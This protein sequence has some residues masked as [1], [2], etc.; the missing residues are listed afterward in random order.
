MTKKHST[1]CPE[2]GKWFVRQANFCHHC[3]A[4]VP[5]F[6]QLNSSIT[7]PAQNGPNFAAEGKRNNSSGSRSQRP[8]AMF[9]EAGII[10][11]LS[12]VAVGASPYYPQVSIGLT[13]PL[14]AY[15]VP[16]ILPVV[17]SSVVE[18]VRVWR[19]PRP[20]ETAFDTKPDSQV[21]K[22]EHIDQHGRPRLLYDFPETIKL[23]HLVHIAMRLES[24]KNFSRRGMVQSGKLSQDQFEA[25]AQTLLSMRLA[26]R[27]YPNAKNSPVELR[28]SGHSLFQAAR[29]AK[30]GVVV[31]GGWMA[32]S[33]NGP[34]GTGKE[35][36]QNA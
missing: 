10:S 3:G 28:Q 33:Q 4:S 30:N 9:A 1:H 31:G 18:I 13:I 34:M 29:T 11:A 21:V 2:C 22:V 32:H 12:L 19:E 14:L 20:G 36:G 7:M 23:A 6:E 5:N 27:K 25:I 24:G 26:T 15:T 17:S 16:K 8:K 35:G